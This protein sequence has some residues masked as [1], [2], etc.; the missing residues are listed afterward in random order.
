MRTMAHG[1]ILKFKHAGFVA[2]WTGSNGRLALP[3]FGLLLVRSLPLAFVEREGAEPLHI[4]I[5]L[6]RFIEAK[7]HEIAHANFA[8]AS[9]KVS[10]I[11]HF[12]RGEFLLFMAQT[13]M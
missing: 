9:Q 8:I 3:G 11:G 10:G 1:A 13:L 7:M 4:E 2:G 5:G 6:A 12:F